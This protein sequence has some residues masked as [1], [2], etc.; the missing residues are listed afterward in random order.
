MEPEVSDPPSAGP[1]AVRHA[2]L[3]KRELHGIQPP[4]DPAEPIPVHAC[5]IQ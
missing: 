1:E 4:A 5:H 2:V 3:A